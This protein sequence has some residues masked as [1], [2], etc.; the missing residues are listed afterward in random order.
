[1]MQFPSAI[2]EAELPETVQ[3]AG[4]VDA[5]LT[6]RPELAVADRFRAVPMFCAAMTAKLI[7]WESRFTANVRL[8][9][10]AAA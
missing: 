4:V 5:K 2:S 7:V 6:A 9:F 1:M 10:G 3:T 8:T